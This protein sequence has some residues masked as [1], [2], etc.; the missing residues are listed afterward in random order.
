M[1]S[2]GKALQPDFGRLTVHNRHRRAGRIGRRPKT[3]K[4]EC[5]VQ[6]HPVLAGRNNSD[7]CV[8]RDIYIWTV[9][10]KATNCAVLQRQFWGAD[11][12]SPLDPAQVGGHVMQG[13]VLLY[14]IFLGLGFFR[15]ASPGG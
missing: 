2:G 4:P 3:A 6:P 9:G 11:R 13:R 15:C 14:G 12:D 1:L 10:L 5:D 7:R 8:R